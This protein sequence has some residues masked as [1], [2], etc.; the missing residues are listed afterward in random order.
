MKNNTLIKPISYSAIV[1][2]LFSLLIYLIAGSPE[3]TIWSSIG[4]IIMGTLRTMQWII[5]MTLALIVCL[6]FLFAI[7]FGA[8]ALF[9]REISTK[10]YSNFKT[11]LFSWLPSFTEQCCCSTSAQSS[12]EEAAA[13]ALAVKQECKTMNAEINNIREHLHTTGQALT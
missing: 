4:L 3:A 2:A 11:L 7:F 8:V 5:A 1:L 12:Q 13:E 9:D 10:M 6:A